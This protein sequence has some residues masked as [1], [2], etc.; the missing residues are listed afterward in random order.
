ME[1]RTRVVFLQHPREAR[2]PV[3]TCRLAHLSLPNSELHIGL[4]AEG[5]AR[6]EALAR[7]PGTMVLFPGPGAIDARELATPPRTLIVVDGTW[8]NARKVVQRSP[9]LAALPRIGFTPTQPSNYRIRR[10]PAAHCV[11][12]IEA[13]AHVLEALEDAPGRF[14][15]ML[16]SFTRMVDLQLAYQKEPVGRTDPPRHAARASPA[17]RLRSLGDRLVLLFVDGHA[18]PEG[19][20]PLLQWVAVRPATGE[21]FESVI[22]LQHAITPHG[23]RAG[24]TPGRDEGESLESATERWQRFAAG[25][26]AVSTWGR[27]SVDLLRGIGIDTGDHVDLKRLVSNEVHGPMGGVERL[28]ESLGATLPQDR[29]RA[30][31]KL[32]ALE[33][34]VQALLA[35]ELKAC[36][37][38]AP[39]SH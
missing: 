17:D 18:P 14:A 21:R 19:S 39:Q 20:E 9:L 30:V 16:G 12:T 26:I 35:G 32:A 15:P 13:V 24:P 34:V 5:S 7:E 8:I 6:L 33:T 1:S 29:G 10:E 25:G 36:T 31:R 11:S 23:L 37:K 3:T 28:A 27:Y 22:R 4:R 2:V 38:P